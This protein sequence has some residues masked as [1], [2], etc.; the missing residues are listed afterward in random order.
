MTP[1]KLLVV[2]G[3]LSGMYVALCLARRHP[4]YQVLLVEQSGQ[5]GG[6]F[7]SIHDENGALYDYGMHMLY[8]ACDARIDP[9]LR[10]V[11]A[12]D[13]W[14]ILS[15]NSKDVAGVYWRGVLQTNSHYL[16]L[17]RLDQSARQHYAPGLFASIDGYEQWQQ[18]EQ[19][20]V[21]LEA[22]FG[23]EIANELFAPVLEKIWGI[24]PEALDGYALRMVSMDRVVWNE[25]DIWQELSHSRRLRS[26]LA[27]P[28]Q[29]RLPEQLRTSPQ[30]ALYP[31]Q[32][33][34]AH[35]IER[36]EALLQQQGV[37]VLKNVRIDSLA[38]GPDG[39]L[40]V[41]WQQD[42]VAGALDNVRWVYWSAP[43]M[44]L[45][46]TQ[47]I[48]LAPIA[49][50]A[51]KHLG[52]AHFHLSQPPRCD[53]LYYF[54]CFDPAYKAFRVTNYAAYCQAAQTAAGFPVC[55]EMHYPGTEP[56][57]S[58]EA[59]AAEALQA[60]HGMGIVDSSYNI[61]PG[62]SHVAPRAFPVP[63]LKNKQAFAEIRRQIQ[64]RI[65]QGITLGGVAP[66]LG[67]FFLH[68]VLLAAADDLE[69]ISDVL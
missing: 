59:C 23:P 38:Q 37:Q 50:D 6:T 46:R 1:R 55:V 17:R 13:E 3:G 40:T 33:G 31:K 69:R 19:C 58:A 43:L 25:H 22:K 61:R 12:E 68:E 9:V 60:L 34:F 48:D 54:Y 30:R 44:Q 57:P 36:F 56:A 66:D 32:Y 21:Y 8:E 51:P 15:G 14:H 16:D 67:R 35:Y 5:L 53:D 28:D 49:M 24:A 27:L 18:A 10:E 29:R 47:A 45:A 39:R 11:M 7:S 64:E 62:P 65:P 26:R 63:T 4:A 42:G 52:F 20:A 41:H 2:G